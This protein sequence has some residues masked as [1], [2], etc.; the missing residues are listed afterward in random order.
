[1]SLNDVIIITFDNR[2]KTI[3]FKYIGSH[4]YDI[5]LK[6][7]K[8]F[9]APTQLRSVGELASNACIVLGFDLG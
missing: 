4:C 6:R 1:M 9:V 2:I 3:Q 5:V 7:A 8:A